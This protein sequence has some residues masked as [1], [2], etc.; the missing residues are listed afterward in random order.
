MLTIFTLFLSLAALWL[1]IRNR[2]QSSLI[3]HALGLSCEAI[4]SLHEDVE[5]LQD[6][7]FEEPFNSR[8]AFRV[9]LP[10][11]LSV[12]EGLTFIPDPNDQGEN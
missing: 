10:P 6:A 11:G 3:T 9:I 8:G 4:E 7:V 12:A 2:R 1:G 5:E